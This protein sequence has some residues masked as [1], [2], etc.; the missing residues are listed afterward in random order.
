MPSS[1]Q[2]LC[3][4]PARRYRLSM[5]GKRNTGARFP[6]KP[7]PPYAL[8]ALLFFLIA[9]ISAVTYYYHLAQERA[10]ER[11][12]QN[13]LAAISEMKVR[14]LSEWRRERMGNAREILGDA[15]TMAALRGFVQSGGRS[16]DGPK[17]SHWLR[18]VCSDLPYSDAILTDPEGRVL[19]TAGRDVGE[20]EH[21]RQLG[22]ETAASPGVVFRDFHRDAK[23][24]MI[25][26]GLNVPLRASPGAPAFGALMFAMDPETYLY[27]LLRSWPTS[28]RS[29]E[30]GLVRLEG[31]DV[32]Y[33]NNLRGMP[34]SALKVRV[35]L[36]RVHAPG[37]QAIR[38]VEGNVEGIDYTGRPV[39]A[40][41]RHI[42]DSPWYLFTTVDAE[43]VRAPIFRRSAEVGVAAICLILAAAAGVGLLWRR[44]EAL[45]YRDRYQAQAE[46]AALIGHYDSLARFGNDIILLFDSTGRLV[47]VN[48]RA[49]DA[50]GYSREELLSMNL[51]DLRHPSTSAD[52]D[53]QWNRIGELGSMVFE[54]VHQRR[55]G[56]AIPVEVSSRVMVAEGAEFRQSII[57]DITERKVAEEKLRRMVET[58][59]ESETRFRGTFEQAAVGIAHIALDGRL[60]RV[61]QRF[62]QIM[63]YSVEEALS[64]TATG[65]APPPEPEERARQFGRLLSGEVESVVHEQPCRRKDGARVWVSATTSVLRSPSGA[66][67]HFVTVVEDI[68][69]RREAQAALALSETR[70]RQ[71]V[72]H[73][74]Q[75]ILVEG[76]QCIQYANSVAAALLGAGSPAG[77]TGRPY[78]D[79]VH[80]EEREAAAERLE[81]AVSGGV[82]AEVERRFVK[83][84]GETLHA[85]ASAAPIEFDGQPAA[86][87]FF[88]DIS[89]RKRVEAERSLLEAQLRQSQKMESV[90]QLAGGVA[91]DFNNH[92]TVINGYCDLLV[93]QIGPGPLRESLEEIRAA[94]ERAAALTQQLLAFSRKQVI[95][96][97]AVSLSDVV[98][99][100]GKM[101]RRLIGEDIE[102]VMRPGPEPAVVMAD[103]GQLSQVLMNLA[104]N[105]RDAMP[106]GGR[107]TIETGVAD[108]DETYR[109]FDPN[110]KP[111][112]Y[113]TLSVADNGA[114]MSPETLQRI[115]EPFF[116]TKKSGMGTGLG[117][118]TVYGI[119][120]QGG[121][122]IRVYSE[123]GRGSLFQV[124]LPRVDREPESAAAA[125]GVVLR[126][127]E[128]VLVVEDHPE[129]RRLTV[130]ILRSCGYHV[131]EAANGAD[132][133]SLAARQPGR[134]DLLMTDVV[135]PGMNGRELAGCLL[136]SRPS[137]RVLYMSGYTG[138]I[139]SMQGMLDS[140]A[141]YLAKPFT[142]GQLSRKVREAIGGAGRAPDR[143]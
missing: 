71:L 89:E 55:D 62:A 43:E 117:L 131:L 27:P 109:S 119:V 21:L 15:L 142:A 18:V 11:E 10:I 4:G 47:E 23:D 125:G 94:G 19:L 108:L 39:F 139:V 99:E 20:T 134:I 61:N 37:V 124:F 106:K 103:R 130:S 6:A 95:E 38:G 73:A 92:L 114:G 7:R 96:L 69:S 112:R 143:G 51:R 26:L 75:G 70:F 52:L 35:P 25:H 127:T 5:Q 122:W 3:G 138:E 118:A 16:A 60:I 24:G 116:T 107:L 46:R 136:E 123:L 58:L 140:G 41:L 86:L 56:S 9:A 91:H 36:S 63:G 98:A 72:E 14:Q 102:I 32:I 137:L 45:Y 12:V 1:A 29:G 121:G 81:C 85:D 54:T 34:D 13:Q 50:Y 141:A 120:R 82:A 57:R 17:I 97:K 105:A 135:M 64:T 87:I 88:R 101:I 110:A 126:G 66:P 132:A 79:F 33:L 83:L 104:V 8:A 49:V 115:F 133:L 93:S 42:P 28:S 44:R 53:A 67:V 90:G 65:I 129:V 78:L 84:D 48:D 40:S 80:P 76:G 128:T 77:V 31:N 2:P 59:E 113:A 111:G 22:K 68:T 30:T 74:P 100:A